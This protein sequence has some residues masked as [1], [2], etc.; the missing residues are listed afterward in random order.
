MQQ[1]KARERFIAF[2]I[3]LPHHLELK[4]GQKPLCYGREQI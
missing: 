3:T 2:A 1:Q 4:K